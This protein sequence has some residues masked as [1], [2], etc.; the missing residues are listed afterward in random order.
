VTLSDIRKK[1]I[2]K[3]TY[4]EPVVD[5]QTH[6]HPSNP[7]PY[8]WKPAPVGAGTGSHRYGCGLPKKTP[9]SPVKNPSCTWGKGISFTLTTLTSTSL[10]QYKKATLFFSSNTASIAA[11]IPTIDRLHN[12]LNPQTK[13]QYHPSIL[14]AMKLAQKKL[15]QYYSKT[16][17]SSV[18][19]IAM[20][21]W[22]LRIPN[23]F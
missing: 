3:F 7:H 6:G 22:W 5:P 18:Y 11:I 13:K 17:L 9:G 15:N 12:M 4:E 21:I 10:Q 16:D 14:V 2:T 8:P 1:K 20:G 23:T 19:R